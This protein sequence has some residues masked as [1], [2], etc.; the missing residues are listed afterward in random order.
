MRASIALLSTGILASCA[1]AVLAQEGTSTGAPTV[2]VNYKCDPT[3]CKPPSCFCSSQNPPGGLD[4]KTI[5]QFIT[6]TF[7]DAVNEPIWDVIQNMTQGWAP[8]PNGCPHAST[9]FLSNEYT[10][11]QYVTELHAMGH[12]VA[13]HTVNHVG[14]PPLIEI[15]ASQ[16]ITNA[17]AG[18]PK[19]QLIGFRHP[20]LAFDGA[21]FDELYGLGTF[22]YD[23]S[24]PVDSAASAGWPYTLDYGPAVGCVSGTCDGN[25]TYPGL[26]EVPLF[27][28]INTDLTENSPMDPNPVPGGTAGEPTAAE[29]LALLKFN[30]LRH[31]NGTRSPMGIYIHAAT[32]IS[33]PDRLAA[34]TGFLQWVQDNYVDDVYWVNNQQLISWMLNP[35]TLVDSK[36]SPTLGCHLPAIAPGNT[37]ICDGINNQGVTGVQSAPDTPAVLESCAFPPYTY[38]STCFGCPSIVPNISQ[39]LPPRTAGRTLIPDAGCGAQVWDPIAATCVSL[40]RPGNAPTPAANLPIPAGKKGVFLAGTAPVIPPAATSS[41]GSGAATGTAGN[42]SNG[43]GVRGA[44]KSAGEAVS[45]WSGLVAMVAAAAAG[46]AAIGL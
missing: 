17:F 18:I 2:Q 6:L 39:A 30:F 20:F 22:L 25:F 14:N 38:F 27:T 35:T 24:M 23:S 37:E 11:Y 44:A 15:Q 36:L 10:D 40:S 3:V 9:F 41:A 12:E 29:I 32:Q 16:Q 1:T 45:L 4:P 46:L 33:L 8:N 43:T 19:N 13:V 42:G 5:P 26:W 31:Y 28:L 34:F 21:S 7:D